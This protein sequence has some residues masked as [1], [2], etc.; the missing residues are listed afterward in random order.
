MEKLTEAL[1]SL[2]PDNDEHW[3]GEGLPR[4]DVVNEMVPGE[5][6]RQA[7]T[8][9]A[10]QFNRDAWRAQRDEMAQKAELAD[11]A[12]AENPDDGGEPAAAQPPK[13]PEPE[14]DDLPL[15]AELDENARLALEKDAE[16]Q[17]V[18]AEIREAEK[19]VERQKERVL[20]LTRKHD[21]LVFERE[22]LKPS[23]TNGEAIRSYIE[24]Q[25]AA[26]LARHEAHQE[27]LK[28]ID[29]KKIQKASPLDAA[30]A[31]KRQRGTQRPQ[32]TVAGGVG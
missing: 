22:Q 11:K 27:I 32:R 28:G 23:P 4:V 31:R 21:Q 13:E 18:M 30:M 17:A 20:E 2:D 24:S 7:I 12:A 14:G 15:A 25:N 8:D 3:T 10:P 5:V 1:A 9:T 19:E 29:L 16:A 6:T 26:R